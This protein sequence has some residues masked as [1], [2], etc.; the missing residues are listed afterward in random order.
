MKTFLTEVVE[1][2][3][4]LIRIERLKEMPTESEVSAMLTEVKNEIENANPAKKVSTEWMNHQL[5]QA[6]CL[7]LEGKALTMVKNLSDDHEVN[8]V[9]GWCKLAQDSSSMTGQRLKAALA[10]SL[11]N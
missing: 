9:M 1:Y 10:L 7:N 8:G 11:N 3:Y 2:K 4:L 5:F 6:L